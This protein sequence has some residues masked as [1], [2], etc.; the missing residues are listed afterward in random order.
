MDLTF[1]VDTTGSMGGEINNVKTGLAAV[2][3]EAQLASQ[4]NTLRLGL[5]SFDGFTSVNTFGAG[6][7]SQDFVRVHYPLT[8]NVAGVQ[9]AIAGTALNIGFGQGGPE[10]SDQ[11]KATAINLRTNK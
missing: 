11:A 1:I 10:A 8:T 2:I 5:I 4:G 6:T 9:A 7:I 3:A